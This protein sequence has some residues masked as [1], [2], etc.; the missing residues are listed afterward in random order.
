MYNHLYNENDLTPVMLASKLNH[1]EILELLLKKDLDVNAT[2][3][4]GKS[5][6]HFACAEGNDDIVYLLI[7]NGADINLLDNDSKS[8]IYYAIKGEFSEVI[9]ELCNYNVKLNNDELNNLTNYKIKELIQSL[10]LSNDESE[11]SQIQT[12][13]SSVFPVPSLSPE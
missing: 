4:E 2:N 9:V 11:S 6:L 10:L 8:P 7:Q 3:D 13:P 5:A 1:Y 12:E